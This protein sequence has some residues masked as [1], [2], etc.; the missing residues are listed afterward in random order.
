MKRVSIIL[1]LSL[2]ALFLLASLTLGQQTQTAVA[3]YGKPKIDAQMDEVWKSAMEYVTDRYVSGTK[4]KVAYAKFRVLWDEDSI[5]VWAEVY[6]SL[7]NK[8]NTNP[9]EQ[10]SVEIFVDEG[11]EKA[12]S[13]DAND[14]Q[15]RVNFDNYQSFGTNASKDYFITAT[16]KTDFGYVVEA[17][18]KMRT[19]KLAEG[20]VIGFDLQV[21]DANMFGNRVGIVAWNEWDNESWR[22]PSYF[23]NLKLEK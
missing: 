11:N 2:I 21:N 23:G 8:D 19:K 3:K 14:A 5:Y 22:N 6:D 1:I 15:Y 7:L 12:S 18:I 17:Q 9:W 16:R 4:G 10:D 13:Y 20:M